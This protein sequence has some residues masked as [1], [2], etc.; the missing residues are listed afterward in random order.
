M[1][2]HRSLLYIIEQ[3]PILDRTYNGRGGGIYRRESYSEHGK[4]LFNQASQLKIDFQSSIDFEKINRRYLRVEIPEEKNLWKSDGE[5]LNTSILSSLVGT[6]EKNVGHFSTLEKSFISFIEQLET[7]SHSRNNTGKYK[8]AIIE[9]ISKIPAEEKIN[10]SLYMLI[11]KQKFNGEVLLTLFPDL[12]RNEQ[13]NLKQ[14]LDAYL[15]TRNGKIL[16]EIE[17]DCGKVLRIHVKANEIENLA[18]Y[19]MAVQSIDPVDEFFVESATLGNRIEDDIKV[20]PNISNAKVCIFDSGVVQGSRFL[21]SSLIGHEEP[22]GPP[23]NHEHGT[24][25]AS[26]IIYGNSLRDNVSLGILKPDVKVLSVCMNSFDDLGNPKPARGEDFLRIIRDTVKRWHRQIK[27]YNLSMNL[28]Y[29]DTT[30]PSTINDKK[31]HPVAAEIDKLSKEH[32]VLFIL[33]TGNRGRPSSFKEYPHYFDE[34]DSRLLSP[35]EAMLALT[36]G[37]ITDRENKGSLTKSNH[38]SPFTRR[39]PGFN[40]YRKPD[41]VAQGGNYTYDWKNFD[42]LSV[43]G[44]GK[45]GNSLAY[46]NGTSYAA[47]LISRLAAH[48]FDRIPDATSEL[49]RAILIHSGTSIETNIINPEMLLNLTGNGL[50]D[51][52]MLLNCDRWNQ[53]YIFHSTIGYRKICKVPFFIPKALTDRKGRQKLRIK[54]TLVSSPETN[55]TLKTG[56]CKS[57]LQTQLLKLNSNNKLVKALPEKNSEVMNDRYSTVIRYD[58]TFSG[59]LL[60][61]EWE[62][63]IEQQSKWTLIEKETPF[64]V[65]ISVCDPRKEKDI[66]IYASIQTEIPNKYRDLI[67]VQDKIRV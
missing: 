64:A 4:K 1:N 41:L 24:L 20:L 33:T 5:K 48:L 56:Y 18:N 21:D 14:T 38:P 50:P 43:V 19:F 12:S 10:E 35:G 2:D 30:I 40:G 63:V 52:K 60:N 32:G 49:V 51:A 9:S 16:S 47:P 42:D 55:I 15:K 7:Y 8:F 37:S 17:T 3:R 34:E 22:L 25:V 26:R 46:G 13:E 11:E 53:V 54:F 62:L 44:L 39:G 45:D 58:K 57:H 27:V 59:E 67:A 65:V 31:V 66:D 36:V 6:P 29:T 28:C 61:G 23:F